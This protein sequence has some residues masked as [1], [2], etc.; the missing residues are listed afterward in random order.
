M[1]VTKVNLGSC[2]P[3]PA[4]I[5][6]CPRA[7]GTARGLLWRARTVIIVALVCAVAGCAQPT[8]RRDW[9]GYDGPGAAAF[10]REQVP[11]PNLPDPIEPVNRGFWGLNNILIL[12][13]A[14]PVGVIYRAVIPPFV[15]D[16]FSD[17]AANLVFPR[18]LLAN[19]VQGRWDGASRE[20]QRFAINTTV[21]V[22]G[23]WDPATQWF[24]IQ[25]AMQDFGQ[26]FGRWGWQPAT[27]LVLPVVGPSSTRDT[28]GLVPDAALDPATYFFPAG[29]AL[30]YND[31]VD[32]IDEYHRRV[33]SSPDFYDD[34]R[35]VSA[36]ARDAR[37]EEPEHGKRSGDRTAATQTLQA[38]FLKPRDPDFVGSLATG[39]I[40]MPVT[41]RML[42]YS[43]RMQPGRAPVVFLVPG[44]AA[45]RLGNSS[46]ALAEMVYSRGFSVAIVSSTFNFE[47]IR[48]G[49]SV[50]V[51]GHAPVDARDVHVALDGIAR[52][53]G[54]RYPNRMGERIYVGYSLGAFHGFFIAAEEQ[55]NPASGLLR[56][57]RFVLLDPPVQ[58]V[59]GM[60]RLDAF[61]NVLLSVP[62]PE[63][64][65]EIRR[66]LLQAVT[67]GQ[68][69]Q[70]TPNRGA[71]SR[72]D[73]VDLRHSTL[74][75]EV[76]MPFTNEEAEYLI[77]LAF[78]RAL[79]GILWTSQERED[80][81]VLLT[82]RRPLQRL[83][84]YREIGDYSFT[85]YM[86]A[87]VLPYYRDRLGTVTSGEQLV[88]MNDLRAI[89]GPLRGN[90]KLRVF[91]NRND[92]L[93][94]DADV[95]WLTATVGAERTRF[96][97]TGGHVGNL[98][99]PAVQAEVMDSLADLQP[100]TTPQ[101]STPA[102]ASPR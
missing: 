31:L 1:P 99:R 11:P 23:L 95:E 32:S 18:N 93:T 25:P 29:P 27:Y 34:A 4:R 94:S 87:F 15:R 60:E 56:F 62:A 68:K 7:A 17:F 47:F 83:P 101:S 102:P 67:V 97:P 90:P 16:R 77:G 24:G 73:A 40:P 53:L 2:V 19:L 74:E 10:H 75:P 33:T 98:Y 78:R 6:A 38:V 61:N 3:F 52:D 57:D 8:Q 69:L 5:L 12:G 85:M 46:L 76:E 26:A 35:L 59:Y 21:G 92:F 22:A 79:Q 55:N 20:T 63:R 89:A 84:A 70:T 82:E 41:R 66:I 37:I 30:T 48:N 49:G 71:Y 42:P 88:A 72:V 28:V 96:F 45:H 36:L 13:I 54:E 44:L 50:P 43:Y 91:A 100:V 64:D 39:E 65:A 14:E 58:L 51:P 86:Y 80:L 81:G 9:S